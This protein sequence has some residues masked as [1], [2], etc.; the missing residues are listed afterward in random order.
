M[1]IMHITSVAGEEEWFTEHGWYF[2][3]ELFRFQGPFESEFLAVEAYAWHVNAVF[4][5]IIKMREAMS[6]P[7][8]IVPDKRLI[9]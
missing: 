4:D 1:Y 3:D 7:N 5:R 8:L 6:S 9:Q 2:T